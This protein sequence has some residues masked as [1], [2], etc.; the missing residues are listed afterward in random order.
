MP[1]RPGS[2]TFVAVL[3]YINGILNIVGGTVILFTRDAIARSSEPGA[4]AGITTAAIISIVLGI[5][6]LIVARGLLSGSKISRGLV[7]VVMIVNVVSGT[8]LLFSL[9]FF[10][11]IL[12]ILWAIVVIAL[13]FTTRANAF[14]AGRPTT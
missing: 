14:F 4:V 1:R 7:T 8:L 9:Q 11:G 3:A 10:S 6:I 12:E 2:V 5:V 13:L